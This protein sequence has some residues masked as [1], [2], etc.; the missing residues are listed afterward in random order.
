MK[1]I[2]TKDDGTLVGSWDS[3]NEDDCEMFTT[4]VTDCTDWLEPE[5]AIEIRYDINEIVDAEDARQKRLRTAR[6]KHAA[7]DEAR[8]REKD[9]KAT[10]EAR[11]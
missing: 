9:E 11:S 4:F 8:D 10:K 5:D 2:L 1:L 6:D 3:H 7:A